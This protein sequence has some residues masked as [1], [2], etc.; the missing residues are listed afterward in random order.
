MCNFTDQSPGVTGNPVQLT[1]YIFQDLIGL[2][3]I[4]MKMERKKKFRDFDLDS[5][6][7]YRTKNL[8]P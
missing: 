2:I 5:F 8:M 4:M 6:H 3:K 1:G 7:L